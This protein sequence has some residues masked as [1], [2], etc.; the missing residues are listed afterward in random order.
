MSGDKQTIFF[1][2]CMLRPETSLKLQV[3]M[4]ENKNQQKLVIL[5]QSKKA[6]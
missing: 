5:G 1:Y 4:S 6:K 3:P 2:I